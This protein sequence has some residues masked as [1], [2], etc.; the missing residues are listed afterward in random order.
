MIREL[1]VITKIIV[2][3]RCWFAAFLLRDCLNSTLS[4]TDV[5]GRLERSSSSLRVTTAVTHFVPTSVQSTK[6]RST[7]DVVE[8]SLSAR[9]E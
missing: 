3:D 2:P 5:S 8:V 6:Y 9:R 7:K 1:E 4:A